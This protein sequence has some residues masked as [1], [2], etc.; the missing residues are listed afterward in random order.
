MNTI[1]TTSKRHKTLA[2]IDLPYYGQAG[3][4]LKF[5]ATKYK[6]AQVILPLNLSVQFDLIFKNIGAIFTA[7]KMPRAVLILGRSSFKFQSHP[8]KFGQFYFLEVYKFIPFCKRFS[9]SSTL[10]LWV[11]I[12]IRRKNLSP[13]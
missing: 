2:F 8:A 5:K 7:S 10:D 9:P 13:L 3:F 6:L 12:F 1:F 11:A 4:M